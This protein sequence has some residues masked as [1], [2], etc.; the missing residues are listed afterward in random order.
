LGQAHSKA[1]PKLPNIVHQKQVLVDNM[2]GNVPIDIT[3]HRALT[4]NKWT[5][6]LQLVYRLM[7]V[8]VT[9]KQNVF[10]LRT[11]KFKYLYRQIYVYV[12]NK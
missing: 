1:M 8:Q 2:L 6:W 7:N 5:K 3:F 4:G 9:N 12:P 11:N 10:C